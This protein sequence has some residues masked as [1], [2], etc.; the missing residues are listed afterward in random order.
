MLSGYRDWQR[1]VLWVRDSSRGATLQSVNCEMQPVTGFYCATRGKFPEILRDPLL[2]ARE[3][4]AIYILSRSINSGEILV[5]NSPT[6]DPFTLFYFQPE[7]ILFHCDEFF[8]LGMDD[9]DSRGQDNSKGTDN[10]ER[11]SCEMKRC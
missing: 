3:R 4:G 10:G 5:A 1:T 6:P 8:E 9:Q 7:R 2:R 11:F